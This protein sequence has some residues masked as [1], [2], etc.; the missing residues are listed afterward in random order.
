MGGTRPGWV[1][2]D[3]AMATASET[4]TPAVTRGTDPAI[5]Y[6]T[7]GTTG[8]PKMV[9]HTHASYPLA[10][11]VTGKYWLDLQPE[12]LHWNLADTGWAKAAYSNLFGPWR[13]GAA[14]FIQHSMAVSMPRKLCVSSHSMALRPSVP[15]HGLSHDG[16]GRL[17]A[18]YSLT[19]LRHC[20]G[21]GEPSTRR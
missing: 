17:A 20:V 10:H 15:T 11:L 8:G 7:S 9:L 18:C 19:Q 5:I 12:D 14:V 2:Y 21:A 16:A 3:A 1:A 6:F 4:F 13:M